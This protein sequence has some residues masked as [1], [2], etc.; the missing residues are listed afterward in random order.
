MGI[1]VNPGNGS[2]HLAVNSE[3][4]VDKTKLLEILNKCIGT[5]KHFFAVSRARR[6]GKTMAA[7]MIDAYY[8][9]GCASGELFAPY[10]I[11][12]APDYE[13]HLNQYNVVHFDVG[14]FFY[15]AKT[16]EEVIPAIDGALLRE[17][18]WEFPFLKELQPKNTPEAMYL[19]FEKEKRKFIVVIDEYDCITRDDAENEELVLGFL[20]YLRGFFKTEESKQF[21]ALGYITGIL[22]IKKIGGES[23]L[24]VFDEYTMTDPDVLVDCF[25]FTEQEMRALCPKYGFTPEDM[26]LWYDGYYMYGPAGEAK[27]EEGEEGKDGSVRMINKGFKR[28]WH[29]YNPNSVVDAFRKK[30]LGSHWRNTGTF[31]SLQQFIT[32]NYAG[33]KEDVV[34]MLTG[35]RRIVNIRTFQNDVTQF[36]RKDDVLACLIHMGYLGYDA[37]TKEAFIPNAEVAS[38]FEDAITVG[39]WDD[40]GDALRHSDEL[41]RAVRKMEEEKVAKAIAASHQDYASIINYHDENAL[42]TAIMVSFYTARADYFVKRELPAGRGFADIAFIPKQEGRDPAMLVELKWNRSVKTA[43]KQI[44]DRNYQGALSD[45]H[46]DILLVRINY[47]KKTGKFTCRIERI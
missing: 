47:T 35:Q 11:A 41:L 12:K 37:F 21:L 39:D 18:L 9:V 20:K 6:F 3:I 34:Q 19:V 29:I 2:M 10:E 32:R 36:K 5:E 31:D 44:K 43:I 27:E 17:M 25:G 28:L 22:P 23:A 42:A 45:Y 13:K 15:S 46:G 14:S 7:G 38:V 26:H 30:S 40:V 33:L 24:N 4:Y 1:Y 8:S 16:P